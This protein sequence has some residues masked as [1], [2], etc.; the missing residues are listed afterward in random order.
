[1]LGINEVSQGIIDTMIKRSI[2][3]RKALA[4]ENKKIHEKLKANYPYLGWMKFSGEKGEKFTYEG[5]LKFAESNKAKLAFM[6]DYFPN[7]WRDQ[8]D[9]Y[10]GG[11]E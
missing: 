1:M 5:A 3:K 6:E 7:G 10:P 2:L 8:A 4:Q 9:L 11:D